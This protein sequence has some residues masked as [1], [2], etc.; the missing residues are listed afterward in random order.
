MK[1]FKKR[2]PLAL[3]KVIIL[4]V[5]GL[6]ALGGVTA[7][8]LFLMGKFNDKVVDP[9]D[10][11]FTQVVDGQGYAGNVN[12]NNWYFLADDVSLTI[13]C[14]TNDV[15]E[16]KVELSLRN[17]VTRN[18]FIT[19]G[20]ITIPTEVELNKPFKV[21]LV[22]RNG[23]IVGSVDGYSYITAKSQ[24]IML[25]TKSA[26][27]AV[28]TPVTDISLAVGSSV[29]ARADE[30]QNVVVGSVFEI[31]TIFNPANSEYLFNNK[32]TSKKVFYR[33]LGSNGV[34]FIT[35][36][37]N[38]DGSYTF[39]A[40]EV[41]GNE[42]S[43]VY[44]YAFAN[45]YFEKIFF[46]SHPD[47]TNDEIVAF[48][49]DEAN[50]SMVV[51]ARTFIKVLDIEV[52]EVR[53]EPSLELAEVFAD[54]YFTLST[55]S[56]DKPNDMSLGISIFDSGKKPA[57]VLL[58]RV[59]IKVPKGK[60]HLSILGGRVMK[61]TT[62]DGQTTIEEQN[63]DP[64][65]DY[66][67]A[68]EGVEY[69]ILPRTRASGDYGNY[70]WS[71]SSDTVDSNPFALGINFFFKD[72]NGLWKLF[73]EGEKEQ[74][75]NVIV[76]EGNNSVSLTGDSLDLVINY[77]DEGKPISADL[78]L[79]SDIGNSIYT[80]VAYFLYDN[81]RDGSVDVRD[82]F[83]CGEGVLYSKD[84]K[85]KNI[86][87]SGIAI[88]DEYKFYELPPTNILTVKKSYTGS[89][90]VVAALVRTDAN[91]NIQYQDAEKTRYQLVCF[92]GAKVVNVES[93]LSISNMTPTFSIEGEVAQVNNQ[94][95]LPAIN[96]DEK[97]STVDRVKFKLKLSSE[98]IVQDVEK[99]MT[100]YNDKS[101]KLSVCDR[102]G[103]E[104]RDQYMSL[105]NLVELEDKRTANMAEFEGWISIN[106]EFFSAGKTVVDQG[107][108]I[109]FKLVYD[110]GKESRSK[111]VGKDQPA[112]GQVIDYFYIYFQQPKSLEAV[113]QGRSD[114]SVA[115]KIE[116]NIS[117]GADGLRIN[118]GNVNLT[119]TSY[120]ETI[121]NL[122]G[123]LSF[124]MKDQFGQVIDPQNGVYSVSFFES[125]KDSNNVLIFE[126][127]NGIP[128]KISDFA[129][130]NGSVVPTELRVYVVDRR[131]GNS[132]VFGVK[133]DGTFTTTEL[134]SEHI[135]FEVSTEGLDYVK[136]DSTDIVGN[137]EDSRFK[138]APKN[139]KE[140]T[141]SKTVKSND[142][143]T[144][145]DLF[146]IY[147][148]NSA[149][150]N[151]DYTITF[152][153]TWLQG[154]QGGSNGVALKKMLRINDE[155]SGAGQESI[156]DYEG[157]AI[158]KI[159]VNAPFGV[160]TTLQFSITSNNNLYNVT[161]KLV[162]S[163][164]LEISRSFENYQS[165]YSD[166]LTTTTGGAVSVFADEVYDLD[167][168]LKFSSDDYSWK[169]AY[170]G[171]GLDLS[172][173]PNG[174]F[175]ESKG[176]ASLNTVGTDGDAGKVRLEIASVKQYT[177]INVRLY[178][179]VRS[180]YAFYTNITLYVNPN[181]VVE[182][183]VTSLDEY[184]LL[185]LTT[186]S[187]ENIENYYGIYKATTYINSN[188]E[189][190]EPVSLGSG[191]ASLNIKNLNYVNKDADGFIAIK[192]D[193][194]EA[195]KFAFVAGKT[196]D[197]LNAYRQE[198]LVYVSA[199]DILDAVKVK[200]DEDKNKEIVKYSESNHITIGFSVCYNKTG[201][202]ELIREI[203]P[204]ATVISYEGKLRLLLQANQEYKV[205]DGF[206]IAKVEGSYITKATT[207]DKKDKLVPRV[208][209]FVSHDNLVSVNTWVSD[210]TNQLQININ[211]GV[212]VSNVGKEFVYYTN[213]ENT[214]NTYVRYAKTKDTSVNL[215][216]TYYTMLDG[217]YFVV[218]DPIDE[219]LASYYEVDAS[220]AKVGFDDLISSDLKSLEESG[221]YES[222]MAGKSYKVLHNIETEYSLTTDTDVDSTKTYYQKLDS[223]FAVVENPTKEHIASYYEKNAPEQGFYYNPSSI[224]GSS[225]SSSKRDVAVEIVSSGVAGFVE[226]LASYADGVLTINSMEK[227]VE[228]FV[229]LKFTLKTVGA[230]STSYS[231]YY[232]IKVIGNFE[233]GKVS[234]PYN[235]GDT[236]AEIFGEYLDV[237][238][239]NYNAENLTYSINL[240]ERFNSGNSGKNSGSRF[241]EINWID[242]PAGVITEN[243][244]TKSVS[245]N[246]ISV[247][248]DGSTINITYKDQASVG[249][250][251]TVVIEK[252]WTVDNVE[253]VG[254]AMQY[255]IKLDQARDFAT[256]LYRDEV[257]DANKVG[258]D[259]QSKYE[260][261]ITAGSEEQVFIPTIRAIDGSVTGEM[262]DF[263]AYIKGNALNLL[264]A[265]QF[266]K[267]WL[268]KGTEVKL[269][270]TESIIL[271]HDAVLVESDEW[272][273]ANV[274]TREVDG[275]I[276]TFIVYAGAEFE[277]LEVTE[278]GYVWG[279]IQ[280]TAIN[281]TEG[282][283]KCGIKLDEL[284][285]EYLTEGKQEYF[286][287]SDK[288]ASRNKTYY[289]LVDG[290]YT[291]VK[292]EDGADFEAGVTYY[293]KYRIAYKTVSLLPKTNIS[294]DSNFE[295]GFYSK[296][297]VVIKVDISAESYY[298]WTIGKDTVESGKMYIFEDLISSL[299]SNDEN[300]D[301]EQISLTLKNGADK[302]REYYF[303]TADKE[304]NT[305]K[306]YFVLVDGKYQKATF[307]DDEKFDERTTYFEHVSLKI[308]DVVL[309]EGVITPQGESNS[310][311][312]AD[313]S[314]E[315]A[316]L[317]EDLA[318]DFD[319]KIISASK[320]N[321][322]EKSS[323]TFSLPLT[324]KANFDENVARQVQDL[325]WRYG[326]T[327]FDVEIDKL[328][329]KSV[330]TPSEFVEGAIP[331][332]VELL[333]TQNTTYNF[334][335]GDGY[336][337]V[338][339][340]SARE[341]EILSK[342]R[343]TPENVDRE[344]QGV[345]KTL[346]VVSK[347]NA[348]EIARFTVNYRYSVAKNVIVEANYPVPD[349]N[350]DN[351]SSSEYVSA[352]TKTGNESERI[353]KDFIDFFNTSA[354]FAKDGKHRIE[355]VNAKRIGNNEY[356]PD[357]VER[358]QIW[359]IS[360]S[361]IENVKL[362]YGL[363]DDK[364]LSAADAK[365]IDGTTSD[366]TIL[367]KTEN[368]VVNLNFTL[369]NTG[370]TGL[371]VFD[372][373]V[374]EVLT[375]YKVTI[376]NDAIVKV[377]TNTPNYNLNRET[378]F[379]EDLAKSE[380]QTLFTESRLLSFAFKSS[381]VTGATYY[382]RLTN[383][384]RPAENK[385]V[386]ITVANRGV[387]TNLDLGKS[388][389]DFD[390]TATF[391]TLEAAQTN[392]SNYKITDESEIFMISPNLTSRVVVKYYD[393]KNIKLDDKTNYIKLGTQFDWDYSE[394]N[395]F[396]PVGGLDNS[397]M[398]NPKLS[399]EMEEAG[400]IVVFRGENGADIKFAKVNAE[401]AYVGYFSG[402][403]GID[404]DKLFSGLVLISQNK[405][406]IKVSKNGVTIAGGQSSQLTI[407]GQTWFV[408]TGNANNFE[409]GRLEEVSGLDKA[410][411]LSGETWID[412]VKDLVN[413]TFYGFK[414]A[415][416]V[417]LS[418]KDYHK[419]KSF[420][421]A[422]QVGEETIMTTG[423]YNLYLDI[424]FGVSENADSSTTYAYKTVNA[425]TYS[426]LF[427]DVD[428]G[429]Y[430]TRTGNKYSNSGK[431]GTDSLLNSGGTVDL[432]IY[433]FSD[434]KIENSQSSDD[435]QKVAASIDASLR[436]MDGKKDPS[437]EIVYATG[438]NPR[439][440]MTLNETT[441]SIDKNYIDYSDVVENGKTVDF[442]IHARGANND[443]NHVMMRIT[444]TVSFG[445][446]SLPIKVSHNLLF[447][448]LPNA[449]VK[450]L[451]RKGSTALTAS[452]DLLE[453][454]QSYASNKE[455]PFA[456]MNNDSF[457]GT[458]KLQTNEFN[459]WKKDNLNQSAI[460]AFLYS[461]RT[462]NNA[463]TFEYSY[464][465]I[466]DDSEYNNFVLD[467]KN[468]AGEGTS[469]Q[470]KL[471]KEDNNQGEKV[472][473]EDLKLGTRKF[474]IQAVDGFGFKIRF[475]F[476]LTATENP[477]IASTLS[478]HGDRVLKE[479][480]SVVVGA[481]YLSVAPAIVTAQVNGESERR[482]LLGTFIYTKKGNDSNS[483]DFANTLSN[484]P[485]NVRKLVLS[486]QTI[487][488]YG[489]VVK[490]IED[491]GSSV[492]IWTNEGHG[493]WLINESTPAT[494]PI[495][496]P[497]FGNT[498]TEG[499]QSPTID[500]P[501]E[502][503]NADG[504]GLEGA[505][506]SVY[507]VFNAGDF[508]TFTNIK[509]DDAIKNGDRFAALTIEQNYS[510][511]SGY[512]TPS[513]QVGTNSNADKARV[514]L[515]GIS[516]YGFRATGE[517]TINALNTDEA[518]KF[519]SRVNDIKVSKIDYF[520]N[521]VK[522]G[523]SK[524]GSATPNGEISLITS[525]DYK[526]YD[527]SAY[528]YQY[529]QA[530]GKAVAGE[531]YYTKDGDN[532]TLKNDIKDDED[533]SGYYV[534]RQ[535]RDESSSAKTPIDGIGYKD[536]AFD[537]VVP[538]IDSIYF[539]TNETLP[540]VR[541][542]ITLKEGDNTCVLSQY[543]TISR[544]ATFSDIPSKV[545]DNS[546]VTIPNTATSSSDTSNRKLYNDTLEV[547][548]DPGE[549]VKF[550]ISDKP[551]KE[552]P[553]A[554]IIELSNNQS[555]TMTHY[556]GISSKI[557]NL[558]YNF[559]S[560]NKVGN[561]FY[562][563]VLEETT[564]DVI[565]FEYSGHSINPVDNIEPSYV[566]KYV[567]T[568]DALYLKD[569]AYYQKSNSG[570]FT[571]VLGE[572]LF[573]EAG[574]VLD[575]KTTYYSL[576]EAGEYQVVD[577]PDQESIDKYYVQKTEKFYHRETVEAGSGK[578]Y[579]TTTDD[580][581]FTVVTNPTVGSELYVKTIYYEKAY[582]KT[583]D[584]EIDKQKT[585]YTV[586]KTGIY[587]AVETPTA[588][589]LNQY[590]ELVT[591]ANYQ[592]EQIVLYQGD[593]TLH[594]NDVS[595]KGIGKTLYFLYQGWNDISCNE[596]NYSNKNMYYQTYKTISVYPLYE[597]I[598]SE[599]VNTSQEIE[600]TVSDYLKAESSKDYYYIIPREVWGEHI[601]LLPYRDGEGATAPYIGGMNEIL[602]RNAPG[603]Q[604]VYEVSKQIGGGAGGAFIDENGNIITD[605]DFNVEES[606]ITVNLY[607]KV[608]GENGYFEVPS[609]KLH[610]G[611]FRIMLEGK[612]TNDMYQV[613]VNE[614]RFGKLTSDGLDAGIISIPEGYTLY[615][616]SADT[617][618]NKLEAITGK[619]FEKYDDMTLACEVGDTLDFEEIFKEINNN[620]V[621]RRHNLTYHVVSDKV[622]TYTDILYY[623][624]LNSYK[625]ATEGT[626]EITL[627]I[628][629]SQIENDG[630]TV[631]VYGK[632]TITVMAYN[633]LNREDRVYMLAASDFKKTADTAIDSG[634][635]YYE[636][637]A[638]GEY[639]K[640]ENPVVDDIS[641]YYQ[642]DKSTFALGTGEW[643]KL[644][645]DGVVTA[646]T[647]KNVKNEPLYVAP[648]KTGIYRESY[649][650]KDGNGNTKVWSFTFYVVAR[651]DSMQKDVVLNQN[652]PYN[653]S[654]LFGAT[655][656]RFYKVNGDFES[657]GGYESTQPTIT[658][659]STE[660][661]TH[662]ANTTVDGHYIV[663][664]PTGEYFRLTV[665]YKFT[666]SSSPTNST[667]FI[668]K[669]Q[670]LVDAVSAQVLKDLKNS[671]AQIQKVELIEANG[672]LG[673][674]KQVAGSNPDEFRIDGKNYLITYTITE[675]GKTVTK[676]VRYYVTFYTYK[677][678]V[679]VT[680]STTANTSYALRNAGADIVKTLGLPDSA[681]LVFQKLNESGRLTTV[682]NIS[683]ATLD[684][685][686]V[687]ETFI[688]Q[689]TYSKNEI[690]DDVE[691][692]VSYTENYLINLTFTLEKSQ[693]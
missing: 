541:M 335:A 670:S 460:Q 159:I 260:T 100:A 149:T 139:V 640:V 275:V 652:A 431:S 378:V 251:A 201:V 595:E 446:D 556:V 590:F 600:F 238:S 8:V 461:N 306:N 9:K 401:K 626:H 585:Y 497:N 115:N 174:V 409:E 64:S 389:K 85:G 527:G 668:E 300:S 634:K 280:A 235:E 35:Y 211:L 10:M 509:Y 228:G 124:T 190:K 72:E 458:N 208:P 65:F 220:F 101:L 32:N 63:F 651:G 109:S 195:G 341:A 681:N 117:A 84:Y 605:T 356:A 636:L 199:N 214:Y 628:G 471:V 637:S 397:E 176:I 682:E 452:A 177:V 449:D 274:E 442:S 588:K 191:S 163:S 597:K 231:W 511:G 248:F 689:I 478:E 482:Q 296:E 656:Y 318:L 459:L 126:D 412:C 635:D 553:T 112:V 320:T 603:Y 621:S 125:R 219:E 331:T 268:A 218:A 281:G 371:V 450:F 414:K 631:M 138:D 435:L 37:Q 269:S 376:I 570:D 28:D 38:A 49:Q 34:N 237:N 528:K 662:G 46:D 646:I 257:K 45:S 551:F 33:V 170:V 558:D 51:S 432:K 575:G 134:Q 385:I 645:N 617:Q 150:A 543:V 503:G 165:K 347:F 659:I 58:G 119:S 486:A 308:A 196:I 693:A 259:N 188:G 130:T 505:T 565:D 381:A 336:E 323:F 392:D 571:E 123:Q 427:D 669:G 206:S 18:G 166:Y 500:V 498:E 665:H 346:R 476:T 184:P 154:F 607:M 639:V 504:N 657:A 326:Q 680:I 644:S 234:Y 78:P 309:L 380:E 60:E 52:D 583:A 373:K 236:S 169:D 408:L 53:I 416:A 576:T 419:T 1:G 315:I 267:I 649:V 423:Q 253:V 107:R 671:T 491:P 264:D 444:Y 21:E 520:Y 332:T 305:F 405:D 365:K 207:S 167:E 354:T 152:D 564:N 387:T 271:D 434:L 272:I 94:I 368:N 104:Y 142:P 598:S 122:N 673:E 132:R 664:D 648:T 382:V 113:Y 691:T 299:V 514:V 202:D 88:K 261:S 96:K 592:P 524:R 5:V 428:F 23:K 440:G 293:E 277:D 302:Y 402:V 47:A 205:A 602:M 95:Y 198:F 140:V 289:T 307:E 355:A 213:A 403:G 40:E 663:K 580:K 360:V 105:A 129:S 121:A 67:K 484:L 108:A 518:D 441:G 29:V 41:S 363:G 270:E 171:K 629:Y 517:E 496:N 68:D 83:N 510:T 62:A 584:K 120:N 418:T 99:L 548:L 103:I 340:P 672:L 526:F 370:M 98:D 613:S 622:G 383:K 178:Y 25:P 297:G 388:F 246:A 322:E 483:S 538:V 499:W 287:T 61:V 328:E 501:L 559:H 183:R 357:N 225:G 372:V 164:D 223:T 27:I 227:D 563:T 339:E 44:A 398:Y 609:T 30:I 141:V 242:K 42:Y 252:Y 353:S 489:T 80:K 185:D 221:V 57:Q 311:N 614:N 481:Q 276:K 542:D 433:G 424:E 329:E 604:F 485:G 249:T 578:T 386:P 477:Q 13:S 230:N 658:E 2:A 250:K 14:T 369:L 284:I 684:G 317:V 194:A 572:A 145:S 470:I 151:T 660:N 451:A 313:I 469:G 209:T 239:G 390:Y 319:V 535:V 265:L 611:T 361:Q 555:Y 650:A 303:E 324:V 364:N 136:Y 472:Y 6:I 153:G 675:N 263:G 447:K 490:V 12:G 147:T 522:I 525:E 425:G 4:V 502:Q 243:F 676:F 367:S 127:T 633:V 594:L 448:V 479:G 374:N 437:K 467:T 661:F 50:Q 573:A 688:V 513:V 406:A 290:V 593:I 200:V 532:Y 278:D 330:I 415:T 487:S 391:R 462:A 301:I 554:G 654:N 587:T 273:F 393:G 69:Y 102:D 404:G 292:F 56:T 344:E 599:K 93:T 515:R 443:G 241:E 493:D 148:T 204:D 426:S 568:S 516:A 615:T 286:T 610:L 89:V 193:T 560:A 155:N 291:A 212:T 285:V 540:N 73:F 247:G 254:S 71:I 430:N 468:G 16:T 619:A 77:D 224:L 266:K 160:E 22:R 321:P 463:N 666:S 333:S 473:I 582:K 256:S 118:W 550:A 624:N 445:R 547:V 537:F 366:R 643:Y 26:Y 375:Q 70:Y 76:K 632:A 325:S 210:G 245:S 508:G 91:G 173:D 417:E 304:R 282:M 466:S 310:L 24:N 474:Y 92:S 54:K 350:E 279:N 168:Y 534:R 399:F 521:D 86:N 494:K 396:T 181:I 566:P 546:K 258:Q 512:N 162:L 116:V 625:I 655:G 395:G 19:D 562:I 606:T 465:R 400:D 215:A 642:L 283:I 413:K 345:I 31:D 589:D 531:K 618:A 677:Q 561:E 262:E 362:T 343:I 226:N 216:K 523:E 422:V 137:K 334:I 438:L 20:A 157:V 420:Q 529:S 407:N 7:L 217:K 295:L 240:A 690:V 156:S 539:K 74:S 43:T 608:S 506:I 379:A 17:G 679:D 475:F 114:L 131:N 569:K 630:S 110:D 687:K 351:A 377:S 48:M 421:I 172:S 229:V 179:G 623:N 294:K 338:E 686:D 667:I 384:L 186:I 692:V 348:R 647:E 192:N 187:T 591:S 222:L 255:T 549:S 197:V 359:E 581:T 410:V 641:K 128:T 685:G 15:T 135:Q 488:G 316:P 457:G 454:G 342:V 312:F 358:K 567:V 314:L 436:N 90:V 352:T 87:I 612:S 39:S 533:V 233:K 3:W 480:Q 203:F 586:S 298:K 577:N 596:A 557:Q 536:N 601:K 144:L 349:G 288:T 161:L 678:A 429:I 133:D 97:G 232:R 492:T 507:A 683:L 189:T 620:E 244:R 464:E 394:E 81:T 545:A 616:Y 75:I 653:L 579:Y 180:D 574:T 627:A 106:E 544:L 411:R 158:S 495:P 82:V 11:A 55:N 36:K 327:G 439:Y 552:V 175:Y 519:K 66:S 182:E 530:S 143:I 146:R 456:I 79:T 638:S 111:L 455:S 674:D 59:G 337:L 453:G